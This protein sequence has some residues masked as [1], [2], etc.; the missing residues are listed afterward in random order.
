MMT[1]LH[2]NDKH[3]GPNKDI[4][5]QIKI[6]PIK[7]PRIVVTPAL[8]NHIKKLSMLWLTF[9]ILWFSLEPCLDPECMFPE[10]LYTESMFPD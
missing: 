4:M 2:N 5:G 10:C 3:N 8:D 6:G 1:K 9:L 7:Y